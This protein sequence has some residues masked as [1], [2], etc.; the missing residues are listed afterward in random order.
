MQKIVKIL[1]KI[2]KI[3]RRFC[4]LS[5]RV[6]ER[7]DKVCGVRLLNQTSGSP[8][9]GYA[10]ATRNREGAVGENRMEN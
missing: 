5:I 10:L 8:S 6:F 1:L 4:L 2:D 3:L 9:A 7:P